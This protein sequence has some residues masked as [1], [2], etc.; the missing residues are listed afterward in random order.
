MNARY[1]LCN[2]APRHGHGRLGG[3]GGS[4]PWQLS[5]SE[6]QAAFPLVADVATLHCMAS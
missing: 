3:P 4:S 1:D 5:F 2:H 6:R